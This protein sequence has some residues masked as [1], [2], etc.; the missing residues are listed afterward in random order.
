M[1][2][3][4][5]F[6]DTAANIREENRNHCEEVTKFADNYLVQVSDDDNDCFI[7][8]K[9]AMQWHIDIKVLKLQAVLTL[10]FQL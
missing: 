6:V 1:C 10:T 9:K 5:I 7:E 4:C 3:Y 8:E 2:T